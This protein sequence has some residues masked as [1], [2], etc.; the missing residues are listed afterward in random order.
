MD[1]GSLFRRIIEE[2]FNKGNLA[3][4]D[5]ICAAR[6]TEHEYLAPTGV[7]GPDIL[8]GQIQAARSEM[9]GLQITIEDMVVQG[10]TVWARSRAVGRS[11]S[12]KEVSIFV[13][14]VCRFQDGRLVEHWG[15]PD[16]FALL[17]QSGML[18]PR[19]A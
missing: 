18:P 9:Q 10:D 5:D 6:L 13:F 15:V 16:R 12:G 17:H 1:N 11:K 4:A 7:P 14:D 3:V 19:P 8:K 2:G